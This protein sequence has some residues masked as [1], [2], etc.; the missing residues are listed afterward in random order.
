M[1]RVGP[2]IQGDARQTH[3][4]DITHDAHLA[5]LQPVPLLQHLAAGFAGGC[6]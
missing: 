1:H 5:H 4:S 3:R 2:H 6:L